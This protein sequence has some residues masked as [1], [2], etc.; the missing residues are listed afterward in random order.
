MNVSAEHLPEACRV[1][2]R[3]VDYL[4]RRDWSLDVEGAGWSRDDM[5]RYWKTAAEPQEFVV[6]YAEKYDLLHFD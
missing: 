1:W 5:L 2:L 3:Q 6:W 4:L